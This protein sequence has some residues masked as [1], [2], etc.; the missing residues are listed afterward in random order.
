MIKPSPHCAPFY[1]IKIFVVAEKEFSN[2]VAA[3]VSID[4]F[5]HAIEPFR[6]ES[7][8][9]EAIGN[10]CGIWKTVA[11][12]AFEISREIHRHLFNIFAALKL[13]MTGVEFRFRASFHEFIDAAIFVV[14][15]DSSVDC[16]FKFRLSYRVFINPD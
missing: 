2:G 1:P 6:E 16:A 14:D 11:D 15:Q 10:D 12:Y 3:N 8:H 9:M 4:G 7:L 5:A 13:F